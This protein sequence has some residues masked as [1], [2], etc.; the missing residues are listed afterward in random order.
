M[1]C[2]VSTGKE[3]CS[4]AR[5]SVDFS[6][7]PPSG[8]GSYTGYLVIEIALP[9]AMFPRGLKICRVRRGL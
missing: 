7:Q 3:I 9:S 4:D 5:Q 1:P 8:D 2:E 6:T